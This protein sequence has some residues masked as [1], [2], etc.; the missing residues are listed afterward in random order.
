M[1]KLFVV[2]DYLF[3]RERIFKGS[4]F[5]NLIKIDFQIQI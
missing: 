2:A 5:Y 4:Y 1:L 3:E